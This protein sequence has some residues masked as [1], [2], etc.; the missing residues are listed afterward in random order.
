M[1]LHSLTISAFGPFPDTVTVDVPTLARD[2]VVP[3]SG[4]HPMRQDG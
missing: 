2:G 4:T 1:R 3:G